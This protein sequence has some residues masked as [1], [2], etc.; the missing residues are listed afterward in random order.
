MRNIW[1]V[2]RR[3]LG[4]IFV[5]PIA[6]IFAIMLTLITGYLF[7]VQITNY[8]LQAGFGGP[9][10][11]VDAILRTFTF[12]ILFAGPAITMRLLSE[13]Q[14][15]GT[16][17]LLMTLPVRD[18]EVVIGK[19]LAALIFYLCMVALTLVYPLILLRFGNPDVGPILTSYLGVVLWGAA[20]L[21]IGT[22]ASAL[23]ENQIVSFM[24]AF[25]ILLILFLTS[26]V[27]SFFTT[28]ARISTIFNELSLNDHL[29]NF[30]TGLVTAKD[31]LYYLA[32]IAVSLFAATRILE[33]RRW[34]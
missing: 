1:I 31:V 7:S 4:A 6:Y 10:P 14:K 33:S 16:L 22:L 27:G 21:A 2:A 11:T 30:M 26:L 12:L 28:N 34:R 15:S 5:Q 9:P 18:G 8:V 13:E 23:S 24:V 25:G 32:V 3:E 20:V 17:E 29:N 19:F